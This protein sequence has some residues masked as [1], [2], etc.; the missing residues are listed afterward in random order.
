M[1][2]VVGLPLHPLIVHAVVV[3]LPLAAVGTLAAAARPAWRR[4]LAIPTLL[5]A[6]GGAVAVPLA[7]SSGWQLRSSTGGGS[8][9]VAEHAARASFLLP[10]AVLF[11][12][13]LAAVVYADRRVPVAAGSHAGPVAA[14]RLA[15][16]LAVAAAVVGVA[17]AALVVWIGHAGA[18]AV[19][20]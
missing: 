7:S 6:L 14:S 17:V 3:L 1:Y 18:S 2:T 19:W 4:V 10:A 20:S 5:V 16:G 11:V 8:P 15:P 9:L 13:L 12:A